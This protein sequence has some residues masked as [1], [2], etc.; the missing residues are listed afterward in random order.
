MCAPFEESPKWEPWR[1]KDL[2]YMY[3]SDINMCL[4]KQAELSTPV[5]YGDEKAKTDQVFPTSSLTS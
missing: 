1:E 2:A 5:A 4:A 3:F